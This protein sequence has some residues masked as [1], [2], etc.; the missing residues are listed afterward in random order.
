MWSLADLV[1]SWG[2]PAVLLGAALEGETVVA[3]SGFAAHRGY[4]DLPWV[5]VLAAVGA[6]IGD[7]SV[8]WI[9]RWHGP[10]ILARFPKLA[11][12][13]AGSRV[14][15]ERYPSASI[16]GLRF[17]Y[18]MKMAGTLALG[19][20]GFSPR[21]FLILNGIGA[22]VW[23]VAVS[24]AGYGVGEVARLLFADV[25]AHEIAIGIVLVAGA[26]LLFLYRRFRNR[27]ST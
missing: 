13:V 22:S 4:L 12:A 1:Q 21:S 27:K 10:G 7:Q 15:V 3:L 23:A 8:F 19:M 18:G 16:I 17:I 2:Y 5:V 25:E 14:W 11:R 20:S 24:L 26:A 9:G 6:F